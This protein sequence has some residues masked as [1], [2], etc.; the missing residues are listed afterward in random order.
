MLF[1]SKA[2]SNKLFN[3]TDKKK[4]EKRNRYTII[5]GTKGIKMEGIESS[6]VKMRLVFYKMFLTYEYLAL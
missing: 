4:N 1:H 6:L 3:W 5:L 2:I